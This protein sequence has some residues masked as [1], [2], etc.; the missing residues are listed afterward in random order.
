MKQYREETQCL[1]QWLS[2]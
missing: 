1:W 2:S